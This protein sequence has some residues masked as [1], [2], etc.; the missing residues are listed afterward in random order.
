MATE[1]LF[2]IL[3]TRQVVGNCALWW[4]PDGAGYTCDLGD[5]GLYSREAARS[6]RET[7]IAVPRELAERLAIRH[8][9]L[10]QLRAALEQVR[11]ST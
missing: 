1:E 6:H 7:D 10:D 8:V 2:Y 9:R 5:A 11:C 3:D 4:R